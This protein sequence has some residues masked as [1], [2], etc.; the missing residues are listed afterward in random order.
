MLKDLSIRSK[1]LILV[2]FCVAGFVFLG[3]VTRNTVNK[4]MVYGPLGQKLIKN[5]DLI[6][7][8]LPP[9]LYI[10]EAHRLVLT[11]LVEKNRV[12]MDEIIS[13][14]QNFEKEFEARHFYWEKNLENPEL[15]KV[16]LEE[17]YE[18]AKEYFQIVE[19]KFI[20]LVLKGQYE[21]AKR[22]FDTVL[23]EKFEE[24][25]NAIL[26]AV[27]IARESVRNTEEIVRGIVR[28]NIYYLILIGAVLTG[29]VTI[30]ALFLGY[31]VG[32]PLLKLVKNFHE[33]LE[34]IKAGKFEEAKLT[35][36]ERKDE[37][38]KIVNLLNEIIDYF[39]TIFKKVE[40]VSVSLK[41]STS[42]L[43]KIAKSFSAS[44]NVQAQKANQIA[45]SAEEM[46][47]SIADVAKNTGD[48]LDTSKVTTDVSRK[49]EEMTFKTADEIKAIEVESK[50]LQEV[51]TNLEEHSQEIENVLTFIKDIAEQTNLLALNATIEAAR[52]GEHGK[53][54][55][56]V[57]GE[58]RKLAERTNES[59]EEIGKIIKEIQSAVSITKK[60]VEDINTKVKAGVELSEETSQ[61]LKEIAEKSEILEEKI[62]NIA[63]VT[64]EM[65]KVS[66]Q[67]SSD[68]TSI[69]K[70]SQEM[71]SGLEEI[72]KIT[73]GLSL[74][75][76]KLKDAITFSEEKGEECPN[77]KTC[78]FFKDALPDMPATAELLKQEY[79]FGRGKHYT[80]CARYKVASTL[81]R[82]YVPKDL[83]P[84]QLERA[85]EIIKKG[86][87]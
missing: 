17:A 55:A 40:E 39:S 83:F 5:K 78:P 2:A 33:N 85:L 28:K 34:K 52:A 58:I 86:G 42:H 46:S 76:L 29:V 68:I 73:E 25:Y 81:G 80:E 82:E 47:I 10:D 57:A 16:L 21:E 31:S 37:I 64:D 19:E 15:R 7:D 35:G 67:V 50:K 87:K 54:F 23:N 44:L 9:P 38:G 75:S 63:G 51:M 48:I 71:T 77:L 30:V 69:A 72:V 60:A 11:L 84:D 18:P 26:K 27:K 32:H 41:T 65:A 12:K 59:T 8:I 14:I 61:V 1:F 3:Y 74:F 66:E 24:H 20:P 36:M 4:V 13:Q 45:S 43:S 6:A 53:S 62:Q 22:L 49:G 56:V 70:S 79:C